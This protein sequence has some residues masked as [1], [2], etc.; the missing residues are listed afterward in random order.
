MKRLIAVAVFAVLASGCATKNYG[1]QGDVT[2]MER[3]TMTCREL[4]LEI[5]KVHGFIERV[6]RES[7][8]NLLSVLSF[9]GDGGIGNVLEKRAAMNSAR[10]RLDVLNAT[11]T[12]K[13]NV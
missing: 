1:R 7:E 12:R 9:L 3:T 2:D 10:D 4:D 5:A 11:K 6:E 8:F 13:C